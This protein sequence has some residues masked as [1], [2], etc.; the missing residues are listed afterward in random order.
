MKK[1][2]LLTK[3]PSKRKTSITFF[4]PQNATATQEACVSCPYLLRG[5]KKEKREQQNQNIFASPVA[6]QKFFPFR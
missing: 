3:R 4:G 1:K 6:G 5:L 2:P